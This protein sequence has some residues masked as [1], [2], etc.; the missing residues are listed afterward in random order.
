VCSVVAELQLQIAENRSQP[1][2]RP[3]W[4]APLGAPRSKG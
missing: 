2:Q 3:A 1:E 4:S